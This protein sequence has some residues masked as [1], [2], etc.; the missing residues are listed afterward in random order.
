MIQKLMNNNI[1][2]RDMRKSFHSFILLGTMLLAACSSNSEK[3]ADATDEKPLVKLASVTSRDVEQTQ[4]Y[5]TT[6]EADVTNN[7]APTSPGRIEK[8]YVEVGD[9]VK[10]GQKL[11]QMDAANL[12]QLKLQLDNQK[13]EFKRIDE[14]YKVGGI[15]RSEWDAAKMNLDVRTTSYKNLLEN[16]QLVSPID[17]IVTVRNFDNGDLYGGSS[18]VLVVE[19]IVPVKL[20]I[21]VS[22][23]LF[24]KVKVG[25][26]I[27]VKFDVFGD[28]EF[29]GKVSIVYPTINSDTHTFPVEIKLE[30]SNM[31]VRPGM[32]GRVIM[33]YGTLNH[34]VVPDVA[35]VKRAGSGDKYVY[36]YN[37]GKVSYN[38]VELGR[39]LDDEYEL[40]SGVENNAQV[41]IAGQARLTNGAEVTV[42]K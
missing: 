17:G 7:I 33:N 2:K 13:T 3:K 5:T 23:N 14:L 42:E 21:N 24:P 16:T 41:V 20:M 12:N 38:K 6:V 29:N 15:S 40:I 10:K 30:N 19:K 36:V 39:R 4:E 37:N 22:E 27:T 35:V 9:R 8:I 34:V 31:R 25:M 26:P 1:I 18:P 32:F 28:E 11:V